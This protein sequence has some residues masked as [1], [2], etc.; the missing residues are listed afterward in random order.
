MRARV[1]K[2]AGRKRRSQLELQAGL[3]LEA[4]CRRAGL[5]PPIREFRFATEIGRQW[6]FDLAWPDHMV[7]VELDGGTFVNG[8]HS[9]GAGV[10][11]DCHKLNA[12]AVLGWT[13]LRGNSPMIRAGQLTVYVMDVLEGRVRPSLQGPKPY[14]PGRLKR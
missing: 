6:R 5:P 12:A 10:E 14:L 11:E 8:R 9:R 2:A 3:S 1:K 7:A 13:V 4:A